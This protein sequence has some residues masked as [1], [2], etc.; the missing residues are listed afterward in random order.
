MPPSTEQLYNSHAGGWNR[1]EPVLLSDYTAR[2]RVLERL[3]SVAGL[4]VWDL[5]CGEGFMGRQLLAQH[6]ALVEGVDLSVAM[7][8]A[9]RDQAGDAA[10]EC[11]GPLRYRVGDLARP[12]QLPQAHCDLA[13]AVFLFNYLNLEATTTVLRHVQQ[14]L[15]PGGRFLFTVPHPSLAFLRP[16]EPPFFLDPAGQTYLQATDQ[17]FEGM[18]WRRDGVSNPV[19]SV[20]KTL[21]DYFAALHQ[22]GWTSLPHVEELGVTDAHLAIDPEF[23]GPLK[24][25]PLHLLFELTR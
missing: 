24:G 23:F 18:I 20:H 9:A 13:M 1:Q 4:R 10:F 11:G 15:K 22:S 17:Q 8:E 12:E 7:V 16:Q 6:P 2:P 25:W 19:R 21:A 5:G 3:G 14:A